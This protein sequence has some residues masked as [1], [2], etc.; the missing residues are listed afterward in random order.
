M[1]ITDIANEMLPSFEATPKSVAVQMFIITGNATLQRIARE[2][3]DAQVRIP[4]ACERC[5]Q[6]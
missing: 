1:K 3:S 4:C 5:G 2:I 6:G